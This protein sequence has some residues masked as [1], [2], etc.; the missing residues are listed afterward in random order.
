MR[1]PGYEITGF[2]LLGCALL[3][4]GQALRSRLA[5]A[6]SFVGLWLACAAVFSAWAVLIYPHYVSPLRH[7]P[8]AKGGHWLFGHGRLFEVGAKEPTREWI[9]TVPHQ[10][11]LRY[12]WWFNEERVIVSSHRGLAEVMVTRSY[13]FKR[14]DIVRRLLAPILGVGILLTEGDVHKVQR[15]NLMPAFAF[16]HVKDLYPVFWRKAREVVQAMSATADGDGVA[17]LDAPEWANRCTLDI[18]GL[19]GM[20]VDFGSI[21]DPTNPLATTY[22]SLMGTQGQNGLLRVLLILLPTWLVSRIPLRRNEVVHNANQTIRDVCRDL[23]RDKKRRMANKEPTD[24]DILSVALGSGLFSDENLVDQLMT[25]LA[26]GHDTTASS[27]TWATYLLSCYPH[28]QTRLRQ[29]VRERLPRI[30]E[31]KGITSTDIDKMPYLNAVCNE[32]L[33]LFSPVPRTSREAVEDTTVQGFPIHK[34]TVVLLSPWAT[35]ADQNLWGGDALEFKPERW[36]V[37]DAAD[38]KIAGSGGASSVYAF[39]TFLHGPRSCIGASFARSE[40]ACLLAAWVGRFEFDLVNTEMRERKK[41]VIR[42]GV[43]ARPEGGL[44]VRARIVPGF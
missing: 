19:A 5:L 24:V 42:Y 28:V 2:S 3:L 44:P 22:R 35:N 8:T 1:F 30:D 29:E 43:T 17:T 11:L 4:Y 21:K 14:P 18:I 13:Q 31:D 41:L 33:R 27:L 6:G 36:L 23:I 34:G 9:N 16:R 39:L 12:F 26:A 10:G 38:L 32:V 37:E 25:F 7:L 20:G 40:F 15:R